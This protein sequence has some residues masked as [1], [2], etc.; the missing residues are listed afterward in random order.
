MSLEGKKIGFIMTGS[1]CT[2]ET[3]FAQMSRLKE[4][5][6]QVTPIVSYHVANIDSRFGEA[7]AF[8][9]RA[10]QICGVPVLDSIPKAEPIGPQKLL[11]AVLIAPC[12]GNTLAKLAN[13]ITDT[14][15]LM[16]AKAHMRNGGPLVLA[17]A[18]NDALGAN[19]KNIG[20]LLNA[21][22]V[23]FVPFGQDGPD[24]KSNSMQARFALVPDTIEAA[25]NGQQLQPVVLGAG[26]C[27]A[28]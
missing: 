1:F 10:E 7:E 27:L 28:E 23:F 3:A 2:F 22:N 17:I 8:I 13:A 6:A 12:T 20:M 18:T 11:D 25:L 16:A 26:E 4:L 19:A 15:S 24:T 21:K 5:G 14:P 9:K